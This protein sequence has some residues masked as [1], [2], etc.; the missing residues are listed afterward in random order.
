MELVPNNAEVIPVFGMSP[1]VRYAS[2]LF[3][4]NYCHSKQLSD[5]SASEKAFYI[6][7]ITFI[8]SSPTD[9]V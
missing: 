4:L 1:L 6:T 3:R 7:I 2:S 9:L 5:N 8:A